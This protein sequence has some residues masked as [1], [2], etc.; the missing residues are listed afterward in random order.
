MRDVAADGSTGGCGMGERAVMQLYYERTVEELEGLAG[1]G[2]AVS[3]HVFAP[4]LFAKGELN[5]S[6]R[7][8]GALLGGEDGRALEAAL[9]RLGYPSDAWAALATEVR[10]EGGTW[11]PAAPEEL[12]EAVEVFDPELVVAL[13]DPAARA[14]EGAWELPA[15]LGSGSVARVRGRRVLAL[16][17]FEAALADP[18]A[19]QVMWARLKQVPPL[20]APL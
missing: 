18:R 9:E 5:A 4:V 1:R 7:A 19:K 17:G 3:G 14:L 8:G 2:F 15:P 11:V 16:G 20:G 10:P 12:S 6:E 13:D